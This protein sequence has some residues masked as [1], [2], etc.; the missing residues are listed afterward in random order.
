MCPAASSGPPTL[1][2]V[3]VFKHV[4][5]NYGFAVAGR[6]LTWNSRNPWILSPQTTIPLTISLCRGLINAL[7]T[8]AEQANLNNEAWT[9]LSS[10]YHVS[11]TS[12]EYLQAPM[13]SLFPCSY[14]G[15]IPWVLCH[16]FLGIDAWLLQ[17]TMK[18]IHR[19][20]ADL[21]KEDLG[22]LTLKPTDDNVF[23]WR[24]TI[25]GPSG[26]VYEGGVYDLEFNLPH[27]YP[28]VYIQPIVGMR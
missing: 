8:T 5:A 10:G 14:V 20:I 15:C 13:D 27:D 21:K 26:S 16:L 12:G 17:M 18:R 11:L 22:Q 19:E 2:K 28:Y 3:R 1:P 25:P 9:F 4:T 23:V 24:A 6:T 7:V